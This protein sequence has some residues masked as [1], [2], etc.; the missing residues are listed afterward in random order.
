MIMTT[1]ASV[2]VAIL[3]L[4]NKLR[5]SAA[6][7][8]RPTKLALS[9]CGGGRDDSGRDKK[10]RK[11]G[12]IEPVFDGKIF[13]LMYGDKRRRLLKGWEVKTKQNIMGRTRSFSLPHRIRIKAIKRRNKID[14]FVTYLAIQRQ[15]R[16]VA[17]NSCHDLIREFRPHGFFN[18]NGSA[19]HG[20]LKLKHH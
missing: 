4:A 11:E 15:S 13:D 9:S 14:G 17:G 12:G 5:I 3:V 8:Q 2:S 20:A 19:F 1:W 6:Q 10:R 16:F 7:K 18:C